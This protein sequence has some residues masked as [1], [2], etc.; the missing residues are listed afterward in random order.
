MTREVANPVN[1]ARDVRRRPRIMLG[2]VEIAGYYSFMHEAF[3]ELGVDTLPIDLGRHPFRYRHEGRDDPTVVRLVRRVR[4]RRPEP[5]ASR[6]AFFLWR[7]AWGPARILLFVWA[8]QRFDAFVFST[9]QSFFRGRDLPLLRLLGKR[10]IFVFHGSEARPAYIDGQKMTPARALS[11]PECIAVA[12]RQ[13]AMI[14]RIERHAHVIVAQPAFSHFFERPVVNWFAIG[15]PWK[16]PLPSSAGPTTAATAIRILHSPSDPPVKG[17]AQIR[18]AVERLRVEG[19]DLELI[20]LNRVPNEEVLRQLGTCDF[21]VDQLYSDAPMVGFATEAAVASKATIVGGYAWSANR[22]AF[23][24]VPFP[25]VEEC[26]PEEVVEAIRRLATD[27]IRR[28]ALGDE[29]S[30]FVREQWSRRAIAGRVLRLIDGP[31]PRE[32][33]FDPRTLRYVEGCG[34]SRDDAR[35]VVRR[36][37]AEGGREALCLVDKP[38]LEE[39]FV[40]FAAANG[41]PG[42]G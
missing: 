4:D 22:A 2:L 40:Q 38:E 17:S 9:G 26:E 37:L 25:P 6:V 16:D 13:K 41:S 8:V 34:L 20:E 28:R 1:V 5:G 32:W 19:L 10:L 39:A 3:R 21:A 7:L 24:A 11:I 23:D 18:E 12:R 27:D 35:D 14:R 31:P 42:S 15:V 36:V 30:R 33:M 29:A